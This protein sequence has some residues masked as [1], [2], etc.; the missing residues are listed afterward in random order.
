MGPGRFFG[1]L[2][3]VRQNSTR[4][5]DCIARVRTKVTSKTHGL[6]FD[7]GFP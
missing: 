6:G 3:L 7:L 1:E 4:A 5:A 2:A